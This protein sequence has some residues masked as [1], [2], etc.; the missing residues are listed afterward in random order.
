MT[1]TAIHPRMT[2][3]PPRVLVL[4]AAIGEGHD[5][6]AR[7]LAGDLL[8]RRPDAVVPI[9]DG[10]QAMGGLLE[11]VIMGGSSFDTALG[12]QL[13]DVGYALAFHV[14]PTRRFTNRMMELLGARGL[15]AAIARERPD[16]IVSTYP[17][18]TEVLGRLRTRGSLAVPVVSAI[19]DL[20][21]LRTWAHPG[22]DLHLVTHPESVAEVRAIAGPRTRVVVARGLDDPR[23]AAPPSRE[24]ARRTLELPP[25]ARIVVVSGGGWGV[26]DLAGAVDA[27]LALA[28]TFVVV[29]CGRNEQL[30]D[31]IGLRFGHD[32]RVRPIGFTTRVPDLFAAADA[33]VHSTA[34]LTVLEAT[35]VGCPVISYGWG[36]GHIRANNRGY[37]EHGIAAVART[38]PELTAALRAALRRRGSPDPAYARL[39]LAADVVLDLLAERAAGGRGGRA[40]GLLG[41]DAVAGDRA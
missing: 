31:R 13:F 22:V 40:V 18:T 19:T 32:P 17:G 20:A 30:R 14:A 35:V 21:A 2:S 34:G 33:L 3:P 39:P 27:A 26:G 11:R 5:L 7:Q 25:G 24:E 4:S 9:V 6:P 41:G 38:R 23:F 10:L 37:A 28:G 36:R 16:A 29:M 15:L 1:T 8:T 12:N